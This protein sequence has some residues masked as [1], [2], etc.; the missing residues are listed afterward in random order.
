MAALPFIVTAV[1]AVGFS[2][3]L[4]ALLF[5]RTADP[6]AIIQTPTSA[7]A[8]P[9]APT[10]PAPTADPLLTPE[11]AAATPAIPDESLLRL[12]LLDLQSEDRRLW[13]VI[14]LLR[15]ASQIDDA[16]AALLINDLVETDRT[17]MAARRSLDRAYTVSPDAERG[18]IDTARLELSRIRDD[19]GP[20]PEGADRRLR[21]L[22]RLVLGLADEG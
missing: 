10:T 3:A 13:G 8:N 15:A 11:P 7:P 19:L 20:R 9:P 4:Q 21:Q 1:A 12:E 17:L 16:V 14:Y 2:L 6:A 18:P 22:R 5:P